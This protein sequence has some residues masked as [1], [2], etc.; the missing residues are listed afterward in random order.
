[1]NIIFNGPLIHYFL[2]RELKDDRKDSM[3]IELNRTIVR[4]TR[5]DFLLVMRLWQTSNLMGFRRAR[6]ELED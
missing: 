5:E 3:T 1:M 2:L 6:Y 4:L